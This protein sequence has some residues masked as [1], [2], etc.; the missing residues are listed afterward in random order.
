MDLRCGQC[1]AAARPSA[2][3][4]VA[5]GQPL[6]PISPP[7]SETASKLSPSPAAPLAPA[8]ASA[9]FRPPAHLAEKIR[10]QQAA[11]EG[12][13]R[14]VTVLFGDIAES[15]RL[16]KSSIQRISARFCGMGSSWLPPRFIASKAL[17]IS[18]AAIR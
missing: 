12:E 18:M 10:A 3:F 11:I 1:G 17:L 6:Q 9:A 16:A 14:Q 15:P 2:R 8:S 4:C 7:P 13:R 5:C